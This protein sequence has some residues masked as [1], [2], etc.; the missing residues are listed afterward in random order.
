MKP[1]KLTLSAFGPYAD[2]TEIDFSRLGTKGL[3]L[4]TGD[5]GAGKTTIFDAI[6][7]ALYGEASGDVRK[8][9]MFRSKYA[10]EDVPTYV[11]FI[12]DYRGKHYTVKRNPEY[13]RPKGRGSGYTM[14][15][16]EAELI[17]PDEREPVTKTKEVTKAVTELIGLDRRQFTQITMIA[18]GDF[19]KFLLAG[20]EER[21]SIFRQIFKTGLYQKIQ[22]QLK[23]AVKVQ[24][25]KYDELKRSVNQYMD[26]IIC[27]D[28]T[29]CAAKML[30][31]KK[32]QFDGRIGEG[33]DLLDQL[34][35]EDDAALRELEQTIGRLDIQIQQ[36]D[37][38][39]GNIRKIKEQKEELS[40]KQEMLKTLEPKFEQVKVL[41]DQAGKSAQ[42]CG[43]LAL[44][45]KQRQDQL[46]LFEKLQQEKEAQ[47]LDEQAVRDDS[48]RKQNLLEQ[49]QQLESV[50][51][52]ESETLKCLADI[53]EE[54]QR[55]EHQ[56]KIMQNNM[57][58]LQEQMT[59]LEQEAE[60]QQET[61]NSILAERETAS[62]LLSQI[63]ELQSQA[64]HLSD[65][66][67]L[68]A[69]L[70]DIEKKLRIQGEN[71][72]QEYTEQQAIGQETAQITEDLK[73]LKEK[74]GALSEAEKMYQEEL[75]SY[76]NA[77]E[78]EI[79]CRHKES[80][81]A[82]NLQNYLKQKKGL[83]ISKKEA[84]A[85]Q[86]ICI[87]LRS[88]AQDSQR[89]Q[90]LWK[91]EWE[92][93]KTADT[94]LLKFEQEKK[95]LSDRKKMYKKLTAQTKLL[96]QRQEELNQAQ[97]A[98]RTASEEKEIEGIHY[99]KL[100][101]RFLD[102]QAGMLARGLKDGDPCPVCGSVHHLCLASVP[103]DVP[104]KEELDQ[105]KERLTQA[106]AK[107]ERLS[108]QAGHF[109]ERLE[110]QTE[111]VKEIAEVLFGADFVTE[112]DTNFAVDIRI[113]SERDPDSRTSWFQKTMEEK[114]EQLKAEEKVLNQAMKGAKKDLLR[115]E[116]LDVFIREGEQKQKEQD[117]LLQQQE[118]ALA[119]R[120]GQLEEKTRQMETMLEQLGLLDMASIDHDG[121]PE[122]EAYLRQSL[123]QCRLRLSQA[124]TDKKR[125][126]EL[127]ST[128]KQ[129][130]EEKRLLKKQKEEKQQRSAELHG[131]AK[132][133]Q[134]QIIKEKQ[135]AAQ[136]L[137]TAQQYFILTSSKICQQQKEISKEMFLEKELPDVLD[138][139]QEY[140]RILAECMEE[141]TQEIELRNRLLIRQEQK[142]TAQEKNREQLTKLDKQL[143]VIKN[144]RSEK[145]AQ[146]FDMISSPELA[147]TNDFFTTGACAQG[148]S[149]ET[150][151]ELSGNLEKRLGEQLA[152]LSE[153]LDATQK[154]LLRKQELETEIPLKEAK[155][156]TLMQTI[157]DLELALAGKKAQ[158]NARMQNMDNL[159]Q[160]LGTDRKED[161]QEQIFALT[162]R[163]QELEQKL[164]QAQK[165]YMECKTDKE[166][167]SAAIDTLKEQIQSAGEAGTVEEKTVAVRKEQWQQEKKECSMLRDQKHT[168]CITNMEIF[169]KVKAKQTDITSV[170]KKYT[171][172]RA[173]ADTANG[174]LNGKQKV[175]LETYIQMTYFDRILQR[176]NRRLLTMSSGQYELKREEESTN[177][178]GK[179]GLELCV[180][181]HYNATQR[182]VKTLSGGES[183]EASLSLALGL[184]D[185]IQS[186]AGG[187][188]MD[189]MFVD[190]GFGSLDEE[191][192][193]QAMKALMRLTEGN[194]LVGVISHVAELKDRIDR[195]I[196]VTKSRGKDG[197]CS[198]VEIE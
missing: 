12:F 183:F 196:I 14:Q 51:K 62:I 19:Q 46:V 80:E 181:D 158:C 78:A 95:E 101:H 61:E 35:K 66:D 20:T 171:W 38:L 81:A 10:R 23:T 55:L 152:E 44:Q 75:S 156:Q 16:A 77:R 107:A 163:R 49:K 144:R 21:S 71:L 185:E 112:S 188:Q 127:E 141:V 161:A 67:P 186:Y 136:I 132:T 37:Q 90:I 121:D 92:G 168:A 113:D 177:L 58:R 148:V 85:Q 165:N 43:T 135:D 133:L 195:K 69:K 89:Q 45:I 82:S 167:L 106:E 151:K 72:E 32:D 5:T 160:Q 172:L 190:E 18:Q 15:K 87:Q 22:E 130:E 60:K 146:L 40:K 191:A 26:S 176:A 104:Q 42:E 98:Y 47:Q 166:R 4:I 13:Q 125:L 157:Q 174:T 105:E 53:G 145:A 194:R 178:K 187:I 110:E 73:K 64:D 65:R 3:Y 79:H 48:D 122:I 108:A 74:E 182:S 9:D 17:Y 120:N 6:A 198:Y 115:K 68:L 34:C 154:K 28:D 184:S 8:S 142:K 162:I 63:Q 197:I 175:E 27:T 103:E 134:K 86:E 57:D 11:E 155:I 36:E 59:G 170:E 138:M 164:E 102:A 56:K 83:E 126:E 116:E 131:Q 100:E 193:G 128:V 41:Y 179:A 123:E 76:S 99:R 70:S 192:L 109:K 52:E 143:E 111:N 153:E 117:A 137:V 124:Q 169:R 39:I 140:G 88:Q 94:S 33:M 24:W 119:A 180:I 50:W 84:A 147:Q 1:I 54:K 97:Q 189:A 30:E 91:Q 25:K 7:F 129:K 139:I 159:R 173:L 29:P 31:F 150:L 93:I 96:S 149:E 2:K 114:Q 118:Q